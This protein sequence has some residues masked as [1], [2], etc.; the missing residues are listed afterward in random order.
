LLPET[1]AYQFVAKRVHNLKADAFISSHG[2]VT[3]RQVAHA[4]LSAVEST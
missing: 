4:I 2:D 1:G 3:G